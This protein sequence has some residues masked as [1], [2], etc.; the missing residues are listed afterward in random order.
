[1]NRISKLFEEKKHGILSVYFTA[2]YPALDETVRII[3]DL[4]DAGADMI[5]I[6]MPF[7][8]PLADGVIIQQ[9]SQQALKN[10]MSIRLLFKQVRNI[11]DSV[12]IPLLLMGYLNPILQFG[13]E[14]FCSECERTGIDGVIIPDMPVH[15][16][17][18]EYREIFEKYGLF[19]IF[20][21]SPETSEE[22]I[23]QI[24][25]ISKGFIYMVS[26]SSTTGIKGEISSEQENYF[27]RIKGMGLKN[28]ALIGFGISDHSTYSKACEY[29]R[30]VIIGSAFIKALEENDKIKEII[31]RFIKKIKR[32]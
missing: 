1:M 3:K 20:L 13:V 6:G 11:R 16:Y 29:A 8:D 22:R 28:P 15:E 24:D 2:G 19:N 21:I 10:G 12:S 30:G 32:Q 17:V 5:E 23:R 9:S 26:S 27:T 4:Q 25:S 7:S 18:E 31:Q 14:E